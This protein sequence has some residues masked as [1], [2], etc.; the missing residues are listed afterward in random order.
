M[1]RSLLWRSAAVQAAAVAAVSV[2]LGLALSDAFFESWGWLAGPAVWLLCAAVTA[3]GLGM[4]LSRTLLGAAIAG[5][6]S[7]AAVPL[8]VHWLGPALGVVLF[9]LWCGRFGRADAKGA[10]G[11]VGGA[12]RP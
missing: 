4:P 7:L 11:P 2:A 1:N 8:G 6:P 3:M 5:L 10:G 9:A 12:A